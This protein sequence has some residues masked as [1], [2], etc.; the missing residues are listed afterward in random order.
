MIAVPH[1]MFRTNKGLL[2]TGISPIRNWTSSL[3]T[4]SLLLLGSA[5]IGFGQTAAKPPVGFVKVET[6]ATTV[7]EGASSVPM[8]V[9][10]SPFWIA[11][12]ELSQAEFEQVMGRNPSPT[13]NAQ[14]PVVNISWNDAIAYCNRRSDQEKLT[15]CYGENGQ[16]NRECT[17]YRLPSE[18][19]WL[20]A[21]GNPSPVP[22]ALLKQSNLYRSGNSIAAVRQR[23]DQGPSPVT[24]GPTTGSGIR[25][26]FGNVWEWCWDF[27]HADRL[28]D[29]VDNPAGPQTGWERLAR[30]GSFLTGERNWNH[31]FRSSF[32]PDLG[33]PFLGMR[34]ARS[35]PG[36]TISLP[37][38]KTPDVG[39]INAPSPK[40]ATDTQ[41]IRSLW[42]STLGEPQPLTH[43]IRVQQLETYTEATWTGRLL[44]FQGAPG[45]PWR[46]L[47]ML[48]AGAGPHTKLPTVIVPFYDVD[49]SAGKDLG[50]RR[51]LPPSPRSMALLAVQQG[52]AALAIRWSGEAQGVGTL[53]VVADTERLYPGVTGLGFWA[54]Q[55]RHVVDW[56]SD[57]PEVD[58]KRIGI[59]GHSLGGKMALYASAFDSRI[60]AVASSEPGIAFEFTNYQDPWYWGEQLQKLPAGTDQ[61]ELLQLIAPRP[62]LLIGGNDSDG[63]KSVPVLQ[64]AAG[65]YTAKGGAGKLV[66][67]NHRTGHSMTPAAVSNAITWLRNELTAIR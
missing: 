26:A 14:L 3:L 38:R 49:T 10:T 21:I 47:L 63:D 25:N 7:T 28:I 45:V 18:A 13:K 65:D 16:W 19:E 62:F 34:L 11:E 66:F 2:P 54:W 24:E 30:G 43:P 50:G 23:A 41:K 51:Y 59:F 61:H 12:N 60:S 31:A 9:R 39:P 27:Y 67:L 58:P 52:M 20:A 4:A 42:L 32:H 64:K 17:G 6:S 46:A 1:Y 15:R 29:T 40:V 37:P 8:E 33:S 55:S 44:E 48:P 5:A 35:I 57:Q 56:L 36:A 53:E 22:E